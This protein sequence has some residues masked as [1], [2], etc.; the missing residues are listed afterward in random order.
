MR[1]ITQ[2]SS[3]AMRE[4]QEAV[5]YRRLKLEKEDFPTAVAEFGRRRFI[6]SQIRLH[7]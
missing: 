7:A 3:C 4:K 6:G 5:F 2:I 1:K